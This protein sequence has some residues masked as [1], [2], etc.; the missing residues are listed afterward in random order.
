MP[1]LRLVVNMLGVGLVGAEWTACVSVGDKHRVVPIISILSL[2]QDIQRP[3]TFFLA[4]AAGQ[5]GTQVA[6]AGGACHSIPPLRQGRALRALRGLDPLGLRHLTVGN[7][8]ER[9]VQDDGS[10]PLRVDAHNG[11]CM[12]TFTM[13]R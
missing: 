2:V 11:A 7:R 9:S 5:V 4:L 10:Q 12:Q 1:T 13:G 3:P 8:V 6:D